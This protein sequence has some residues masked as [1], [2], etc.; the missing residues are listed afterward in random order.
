MKTEHRIVLID[1][2]IV[3]QF[4]QFTGPGRTPSWYTCSKAN[5]NDEDDFAV[6][7]FSQT[8]LSKAHKLMTGYEY[9]LVEASHDHKVKQHK[10]DKWYIYRGDE[11]DIHN[12]CNSQN[13][14][15]CNLARSI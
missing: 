14:A 8:N 2:H 3:V 4:N 1:G 12:A 10:D 6:W 13:M 9:S 7:P 11:V 15:L 5:N